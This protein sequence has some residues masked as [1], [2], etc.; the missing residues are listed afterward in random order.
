M[1][2]CISA[3]NAPP[4]TFHG[5][6]HSKKSNILYANMCMQNENEAVSYFFPIMKKNEMPSTT[7]S[8]LSNE[9]KNLE[10]RSV[11]L[12]LDSFL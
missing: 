2:K 6:I 10:N 7:R 8:Q 5:E 9:R 1:L 12:N 3:L 4:T 11:V